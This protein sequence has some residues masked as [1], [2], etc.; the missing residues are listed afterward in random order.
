ME[1]T[2]VAFLKALLLT[3]LLALVICLY[4]PLVFLILHERELA[5]NVFPIFSAPE[6][7]DMAFFN[8]FETHSGGS[9][10]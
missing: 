6:L 7:P 8:S 3:N 4:L 2:V 9:T 5:K 10:P 1:K